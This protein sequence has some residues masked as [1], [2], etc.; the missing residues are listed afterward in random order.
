M[1]A[2]I[3][4]AGLGTRCLPL[5]K[6]IPKELFP[7]DGLPVLHHVVAEA[8][9][10][11][12]TEIGLILSSG[13]EAIRQYFTWDAA[14]MDWLDAT[15]KR[16]VMAEWEGLMDGLTFS[17]LEQPEQRG[18]GDAVRCAADFADGEAVCLLLG[19]TVMES[20]SPLTTM[21]ERYGATRVSQVA[22]E[23]LVPEEAT[24]YG[25]CGGRL[26]AQ[27]H[28]NITTMIEKPSLAEMPT[29][30]RADG[31]AAD[32]VFAFAARYV[33]SPSIWAALQSL[34]P[35]RNGEIQLTDAMA[36]LRDAE[37]FGGVPLPGTRRDVGLPVRAGAR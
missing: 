36:A 32:S 13:K 25:V 3:P 30:Q 22:V 8:K 23:P 26:D 18:L 28:L 5:T 19:D 9:A 6:A 2:I 27:G 4:A 33:L 20:A 12:C 34:P 1:K 11:G 14:L 21:V 31:T 24:R 37:G 16:A 15:G 17:W 29:V 35:G 7:V 10:A